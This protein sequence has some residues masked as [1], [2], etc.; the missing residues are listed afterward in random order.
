MIE[1]FRVGWKLH[2]RIRTHPHH[3]CLAAVT[4]TRTVLHACT[5]V[6]AYVRACACMYVCVDACMY[7][8]CMC[9]CMH[10]PDHWII[11]CSL[12]RLLKCIS[13]PCRY[14]AYARELQPQAMLSHACGKDQQQQQRQPQELLQPVLLSLACDNDPQLQLQI[15]RLLGTYGNGQRL[16]PHGKGTT[17]T[18]WRQCDRWA[19]GRNDSINL[20]ARS[21][22]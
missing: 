11:I 9:L 5:Y 21:S 20:R 16:Q 15:Q 18:S 8:L 12:F 7:V 3:D 10:V 4:A 14:P 22:F 19:A 2:G 1:S 17:A 13:T 6:R